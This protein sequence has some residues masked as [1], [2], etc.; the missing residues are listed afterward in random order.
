MSG[1][2]PQKETTLLEGDPNLA[3]NR[4]AEFLKEHGFLNQ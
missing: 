2:K 1:G 4:L 3:V